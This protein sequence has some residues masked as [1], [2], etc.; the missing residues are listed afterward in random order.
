MTVTAVDTSPDLR[1]AKVFVSVL[2]DEE[3]ARGRRW[4]GC[5]PPRL[6]PEARSPRE[7]RMKRTPTLTFHYDD[8]VERGVRIAELL[9]GRRRTSRSPERMTR[10]HRASPA[11]DL[12]R[13]PSCAASDRFLLTTHEGPDGDALGSLLGMHQILEPLGKDSVMFLARRSSRCRSSTASCRS[14]RSSTS[15]RPTWPTG[16]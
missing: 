12:E 6:A 4:P 8:T 10:R 7:M 3:R 16:S 11:S 2:G 14:R 5:A 9:D 1:P 13:S 15:R